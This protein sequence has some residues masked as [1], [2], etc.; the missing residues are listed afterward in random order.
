MSAR[1]VVFNARARRIA[2]VAPLFTNE[3]SSQFRTNRNFT[4]RWKPRRRKFFSD[5][6][7]ECHK[8]W[9]IPL[10]HV[11]I[12]F[13]CKAQTVSHVNYFFLMSYKGHPILSVLK[14]HY[15]TVLLCIIIIIYAKIITKTYKRQD[16][17]NIYVNRLD[18]DKKINVFL[19][20][21]CIC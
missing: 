15:I 19:I 5:D 21:H 16:L 6:A 14:F 3:K 12:P 7:T 8:D 13:A 4:R 18:N 2:P 9:S 1:A 10:I 11:M 20:F 17:E